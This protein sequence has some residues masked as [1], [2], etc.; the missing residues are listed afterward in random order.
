MQKKSMVINRI[1][2]AILKKMHFRVSVCMGIL[3]QYHKTYYSEI[4]CG[5]NLFSRKCQICFRPGWK[6]NKQPKVKDQ[7]QTAKTKVRRVTA[8]KDLTIYQCQYNNDED[9]RDF[10]KL[11]TL[12]ERESQNII[13]RV[14]YPIRKTLLAPGPCL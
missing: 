5:H 3:N 6:Q 7:K 12:F 14:Y 2:L 4:V 13:K 9:E 1:G 11:D 8:R 10:V